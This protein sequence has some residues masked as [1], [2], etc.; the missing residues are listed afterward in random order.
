MTIM[1]EALGGSVDA[2]KK[3]DPA[4]VAGSHADYQKKL[5]MV[6]P[7]DH[8]PGD[9]HSLHPPGVEER[10]Y[11]GLAGVPLVELANVSNS[12]GTTPALTNVS[13]KIWAG[14][15]M[16]IVGPNGGGKTTLLRTMLGVVSTRPETSCCADVPTHDRRWNGSATCRN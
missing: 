6:N 11:T 14:Q 5:R 1:F 15:F 16:A 8:R 4:P 12:Y 3:V 7:H 9:P 13:L 2:L 10:S